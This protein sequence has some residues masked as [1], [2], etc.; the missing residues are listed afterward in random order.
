MEH[1][2]Y[3]E[4]KIIKAPL[5]E[6]LPDFLSA[7][8]T[9]QLYKTPAEL[10]EVK[11]AKTDSTA[12]VNFEVKYPG[13]NAKA[14]IYYGTKDYVTFAPR[15]LHGTERKSN[16]LKESGT[17]EHAIELK[18]IKKGMNKAVIKNLGQNKWF[19]I[20]IIN[21]KGRQWSMKSYTM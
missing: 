11:I 2:S 5:E 13:P 3:S 15:K 12:E 8:K 21:D 10:G 7:D 14:I 20:L 9:K 1:Y 17:W 18:E 16:V 19:R 4:K 6:N